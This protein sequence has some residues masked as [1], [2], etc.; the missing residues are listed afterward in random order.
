MSVTGGSET[1]GVPI[2]IEV[3]ATLEDGTLDYW[4]TKEAIRQAELRLATQIT[5][6]NGIMNRATSILGW[7]VTISLALIAWM[8]SDSIFIGFGTPRAAA[9]PL[10]PAAI[11][12]VICTFVAALCC[13]PALWPGK[14]R[15]P[16]HDPRL[17]C[18]VTLK[19]EFEVLR[20]VA[21]GY[22]QASDQNAQALGRLVVWLRSAWVFFVASPA[23]G[24]ITYVATNTDVTSHLL[25]KIC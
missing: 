12:M 8:M 10:L 24:L 3:G 15:G 11:A 17:L 16:G 25:A 20:A 18:T 6:V 22:V 2:E 13:I 7:S 21:G 14:W 9:G 4:V 19:T 23:V 1:H 5:S